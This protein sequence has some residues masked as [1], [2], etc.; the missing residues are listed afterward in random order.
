[1]EFYKKALNKLN[2]ILYFF[3][4]IL[5]AVSLLL[6]VFQYGDTVR[7]N[8][9]V[10][11][12]II[13]FEASIELGNAKTPEK[14]KELLDFNKVMAHYP[15]F[16]SINADDFPIDSGCVENKKFINQY[17]KKLTKKTP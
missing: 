5:L 11:S 7:T 16:E 15:V 12:E 2:I 14:L 10:I 17:D 13:E 4:F 6:T 9:G 1:M 8:K 3:I